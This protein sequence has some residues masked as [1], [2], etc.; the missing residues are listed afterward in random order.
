[1][2]DGKAG[3]TRGTILA[4]AAPPL[5]AAL[6]LG[7]GAVMKA[8]RP[9]PVPVDAALGFRLV[10]SAKAAGLVNVH[11]KLPPPP[12]FKNVAPWIT[13]I[14]AHV[15][16]VDFDGDGWMD[17]FVTN[18]KP[19]AP[20]KLFRNN[21]DGT[22]T[23]VAAK[24]GLA[25]A[26]GPGGN[27]GGALFF[28]YDDD[29]HP[30][31]VLFSY[32]CAKLLRNDGGGTFSDVTK[33]AGFDYCGNSFAANVID[34][35]GDGKLDLVIGDYFKPVD[36][37]HPSTTKIM[38]NSFVDANN[39]GPIRVFRNDGHG[40]LREVPGALGFKSRGWTQ[41]IGVYDLRGTGRPDIWFA[42]DFGADQVY[43]NQGH[44]RFADA[45][46][47]V[48]HRF[49][50]DGMSAEIA[51]VDDDGHPVAYVSNIFEPGYRA[52]ENVMWK[53][54]AGDRFENVG[55]LRGVDRCGWSWG[56][57]FVDL[58]NDGKLDL[59]VANGY[60]SANPKKS[61]WF[62]A[63]TI[64]SASKSVME[65]AALWP[66]IKDA[67][68]SGYQRKCV[69]VNEGG[70]FEDV[71]EAAGLGQDLSD[72]RGVA[73]IDASNDGRMSVLIANAGQPL[74][75][76]RDEQS[77]V[78]HWIGFRLVG[79]RSNRGGFGARVT[80]RAAG[81]T[82]TRE[83]E[84]LNGFMSQSDPRLHFGLGESGKVDG[85]VVRWP[86][87]LVETVKDLSADRYH[88]LVEG[89]GGADAGK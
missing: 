27:W 66:P 48:Q 46:R 6:L 16:V 20:N 83:V 11:E 36:F 4:K 7:S 31:L 32:F 70:K 71:T 50:R 2:R 85:A 60:I 13:A 74:K 80:L 53:W 49:S 87:G 54:L 9:A 51:D 76:Y 18:S 73:S 57:K 42:T 38:Q 44:G 64:S 25:Q 39:G 78:R 86:S 88:V 62:S 19:G 40:H 41:A 79:A 28:D 1:M 59:V 30:D 84:P 55:A 72:G 37:Y 67:S 17:V 58:N 75:F 24:A 77:G 10:E 29:G 52:G 63:G 43:Y 81:R 34:Y 89:Q 69:F 65:D 47:G 21:H 23:D 61:Y 12:A 15:A 3:R 26:N 56:A 22:F 8:R 82:M 45:S 5:I 68:M 35:D 33:K 14:G